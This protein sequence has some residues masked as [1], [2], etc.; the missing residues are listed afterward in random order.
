[1]GKDGLRSS[2]ITGVR[3]QD[4]RAVHRLPGPGHSS[5]WHWGRGGSTAVVFGLL[6][7]SARFI[8]PYLSQE[9]PDLPLAGDV[10]VVDVLPQ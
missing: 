10:G 6:H 7:S 2:N 4:T 9:A 1:M 3:W 5:S 8:Q